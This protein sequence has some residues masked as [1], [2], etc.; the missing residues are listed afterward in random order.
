MDLAFRFPHRFSSFHGRYG[1]PP[2]IRAQLFDWARSAGFGGAEV[3]VAHLELFEMTDGEL[4]SVR[5]EMSRAGLAAA[6]CNPGGYNY[7]DPSSRR[8]N[9]DRML[10][11]VEIADLLGARIINTTVPG[12]RA[13]ENAPPL[14]DGWGIGGRVSIGGSRLAT[15]D[16]VETTAQAMAGIV[17]A[18][19]ARD[20]SVVIE[21]HQ[22]TYVDDSVSALRMLEL[23]DRENAGV[24]PDMGNILWAYAT[25]VEGFEDAMIAL[26]PK[27]SYVHMKNL[28]RVY[29]PDLDRAAFIKTTPLAQGDIDWRFCLNA[30]AAAGDDDGLTFEGDLVEGW[31]F[32]WAMERNVE[33]VRSVLES[34]G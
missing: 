27:A 2:E 7:T 4:T 19:A 12:R 18:A 31:D 5:E 13:F 1:M 34:L 15:A 14:P 8:Q 10:R 22:N 20:I 21:V 32:Q 30:L 11:A 26:A 25:P 29:I 16:E 28:K 17:D 24:N 3:S 33:Y 6:A 9:V 23:I